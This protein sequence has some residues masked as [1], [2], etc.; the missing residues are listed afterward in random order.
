MRAQG[1]RDRW[2]RGEADGGGDQDGGDGGE[3]GGGC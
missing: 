3:E 1:T 2:L